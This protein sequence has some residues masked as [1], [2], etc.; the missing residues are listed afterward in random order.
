[1]RK[2]T[3]AQPPHFAVTERKGARVTLRADTGAVAH[4]FVLEDDVIRV[5][6]LTKGTVTAPPSWAIAPGQDDIA[7][8]GRDRMDTAGFAAPPFDLAEQAGHITIATARL[9]VT[10]ARVDGEAVASQQFADLFKVG[11][12]LGHG[13]AS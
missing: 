2:A 7:E 8:P 10:I 9:R 6:L 11:S 13:R 3:L 12:G 1:M 4:V 5:L